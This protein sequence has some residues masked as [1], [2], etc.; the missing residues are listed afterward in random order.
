MNLQLQTGIDTDTCTWVVAERH[1]V[2]SITG[3]W[4]PKSCNMYM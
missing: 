3:T 2:I 1:W 4:V